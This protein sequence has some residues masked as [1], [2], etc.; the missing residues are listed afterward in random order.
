MKSICGDGS[1]DGRSIP[2]PLAVGVETARY[3]NC[4]QVLTA[5]YRNTG[6]TPAVK[7]IG[8]PLLPRNGGNYVSS[9]PQAVIN[10]RITHYLM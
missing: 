4:I 7:D 2:G 5:T 6:G 8:R 1:R 9:I 3:I 10:E